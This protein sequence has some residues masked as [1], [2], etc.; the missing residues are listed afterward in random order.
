MSPAIT[1]VPKISVMDVSKSPQKLQSIW[2]NCNNSL[3]WIKAIWGWFPLLT[4]IP[5]RSQW[6]RYNLPRIYNPITPKN[7]QSPHK[8]ECITPINITILV[9]GAWTVGLQSTYAILAIPGHACESV[10]G[11]LPLVA[12]RK[13]CA[14]RSAGWRPKTF[15][16]AN[17]LVGTSWQMELP[18]IIQIMFWNILVLERP[19]F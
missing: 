19:L 14:A 4:M 11:M 8:L 1:A 6:G 3:T 17:G 10:Q 2:V 13:T 5:V 15:Q 9:K 7:N 18:K 12:I 16:E